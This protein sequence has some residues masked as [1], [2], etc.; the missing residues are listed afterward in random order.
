MLKKVRQV[1]MCVFVVAVSLL[2]WKGNLIALQF[3]FDS[4][5]S[6]HT[7]TLGSLAVPGG[8]E[9]SILG[10]VRFVITQA[11]HKKAP[12]DAFPRIIWV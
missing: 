4:D 8:A 6:F 3:L 2:A 11:A 9:H 12:Q 1:S 10:P 7:Y 5:H